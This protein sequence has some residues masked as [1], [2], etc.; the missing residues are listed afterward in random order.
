[1]TNRATLLI[2]I[3]QILDHFRGGRL[4]DQGLIFSSNAV[5][6]NSFESSLEL[7]RIPGVYRA[8]TKDASDLRQ[9]DSVALS[10]E[11]QFS[12]YYGDRYWD[13]GMS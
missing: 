13:S 10:D 8:M 7:L 4:S 11:D 3:C 1:M 9:A 6:H 12:M 2:D 5:S